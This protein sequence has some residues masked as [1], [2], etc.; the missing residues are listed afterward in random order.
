MRP[1][2]PTFGFGCGGGKL[3]VPTYVIV[4]PTSRNVYVGDPKCGTVYIYSPTGTYIG[5]FD[6]SAANLG[7]PP[8]ARGLAMDAVHACNSG[9]LGLPL[10][11][12]EIGD[13]YFLSIADVSGL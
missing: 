2:L 7:T 3:N 6:W 1:S 13:P 11:C 12:A 9:H 5:E 4:D 8:K 10:G